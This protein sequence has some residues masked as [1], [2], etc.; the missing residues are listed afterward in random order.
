[1]SFS[2]NHM[3]NLG[4]LGNQMFQYASLIG[5][6]KKHNREFCIPHQDVFGTAFYMPLRSNIYDAFDIKCHKG[7]STFPTVQEATFHF[8]EQLFKYPPYQNTNLFGF[9][10][11]EKWFKHAEAEVK[12]AFTF[13]EEYL[14]PAK[15]MMESLE[16]ETISLHVRRTDYLTNPNHCFSGLEYYEKALSMLP[17]EANV[18]V[19]SDDIQWCDEQELFKPD[20]FYLSEGGDPYIDMCLMTMCD[21]HVICNSSYSWWGAWL[22]D[23]KRVIAPKVWFGPDNQDKDTKDLYCDEWEVI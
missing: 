13:K 1:M 8:D 6:G 22:A 9:F 11:S 20:R 4:H 12:E 14:E 17:K 2:F 5:M 10:Q 19:F 21:Y 15:A 7:I 16:G 18:L 23:S 3:G